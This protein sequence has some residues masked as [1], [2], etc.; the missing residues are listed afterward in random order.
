LIPGAS[1]GVERVLLVGL[2][3]MGSHMAARL[4]RGDFSLSISDLDV[5]RAAALAKELSVNVVRPEALPNAIPEIST[6]ILMLP[7]SAAV[8][9]VLLGDDGVLSLM[10]GGSRII[11]MGSSRPASTK[12]LADLAS[13]SN[14]GFVD[15][16]VSGGTSKAATG[17]LTVMVGCD[18]PSLTDLR[19]VLGLMGTNI[20]ALGEVGAGHAMKS[21]NNLLSAIGVAGAC[22]VLAIGRQFGLKADKMLD[23]INLST[24]RNQATEVKVARYMLSRSF[25]S[26]FEMSMMLKDMRIALGMAEEGGLSFPVATSSLEEWAAASEELGPRADHTQLAQYVEARARVTLS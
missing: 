11:D 18:E 25:D 17:E 15:A 5:E 1:D 20:M 23:V 26:G 16:P 19:P 4:S 9:Q 12:R 24:G 21:L 13:K 14:V 10:R 6:L 22:E 3:A 2:G 7:D 8:E